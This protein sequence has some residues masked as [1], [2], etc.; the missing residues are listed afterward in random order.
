[1]DENTAG[2][3]V[4]TSDYNAD[5]LDC[6]VCADV[7]VDPCTL[8]CGHNFC[9]SV[10][11]CLEHTTIYCVLLLQAMPRQGMEREARKR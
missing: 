9:E 2:D 8:G 1:M 5:D 10:L 3:S 11:N 7:L 4:P 6:A